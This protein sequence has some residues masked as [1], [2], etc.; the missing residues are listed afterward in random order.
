MAFNETENW[1]RISQLLVRA[2]TSM[3]ICS[4]S[5]DGRL[6]E[7]VTIEMKHMIDLVVDNLG[8]TPDE[9]GEYKA[10]LFEVVRSSLSVKTQVLEAMKRASPLVDLSDA[11]DVANKNNVLRR[12]VREINDEQ[13]G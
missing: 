12:I 6:D 3:L 1:K 4:R 9:V 13:T 2:M 11:R 10:E 8:I 5:D 7:R